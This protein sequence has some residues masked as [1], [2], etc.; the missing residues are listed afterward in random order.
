MHTATRM[1]SVIPTHTGQP[2][3]VPDEF[4]AP[5]DVVP[6]PAQMAALRPQVIDAL[7]TVFDPEIP[8]NIYDLGLIYDVLIDTD[9]KVGIRMTLTAPACPAAQTLPGEVRDAAKRVEGVTSSR[10]E[11]V[12]DPPW[13]MDRMSDAAKL[14]LGLL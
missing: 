12:F 7:R 8:V 9:G 1:L 14:Q 4:G 13:A 2:S 5:L 6:D 3:E 10:V 11:L